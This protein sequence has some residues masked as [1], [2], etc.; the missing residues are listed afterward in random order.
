VSSIPLCSTPPFGSFIKQRSLKSTAMTQHKDASVQGNFKRG[1]TP[2]A[3]STGVS[4]GERGTE[5]VGGEVTL[6]VIK[7]WIVLHAG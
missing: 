6:A 2:W 4:I 1:R 5:R 7:P 3:G